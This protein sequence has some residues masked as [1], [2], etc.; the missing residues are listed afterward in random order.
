[1]IYALGSAKRQYLKV[2]YMISS[3]LRTFVHKIQQ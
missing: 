2:R 1:M 3:L